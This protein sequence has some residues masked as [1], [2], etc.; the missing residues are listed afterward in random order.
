MELLKAVEIANR[1]S[2]MFDGYSIG[3]VA[4]INP[5]EG[6]AISAPNEQLKYNYDLFRQLKP[7]IFTPKTVNFATSY[8]IC[9]NKFKE[10][11]TFPSLNSKWSEFRASDILSSTSTVNFD[12]RTQLR[13]LKEQLEK[14]FPYL[15]HSLDLNTS[16]RDKPE[17][18][19]YKYILD[20]ISET[21]GNH[22]LQIY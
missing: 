19:L 6:R 9:E 5:R 18:L 1:M 17:R 8:S 15:K 10:I 14:T 7:D 11:L 21:S 12:K 16:F 2:G 22:L 3:E 13:K 20:A 4:V